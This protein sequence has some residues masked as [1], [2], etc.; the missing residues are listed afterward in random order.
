MMRTLAVELTLL[1][2]VVQTADSATTGP[3][4]SLEY[5]KGANLLGA[6]AAVLYDDVRAEAYT[7][8][9]SGRVRFLDAAPLTE[10]G[11]VGIP[12]PLGWFRS[13]GGEFAS[14]GRL[15]PKEIQC[16]PHVTHDDLAESG[17]EPIRS[18]YFTAGGR[19]I[20]GL[21]RYRLKTSIDRG[22][23]GRPS[24]GSLFG[25]DALAA[26]SRWL[27]RI[28]LDDEVSRDIE[29]RLASV[30]DGELVWLGRSR[31]AEYGRCN[32]QLAN[33]PGAK[34]GKPKAKGGQ[35]REVT[36]VLESDLALYDPQTGEPTWTAR[37][38]LL[39]LP[40]DWQL[41]PLASQVESRSYSPF[42]GKR[43]FRENEHR[44]LTRGSVLTFAAGPQA[45]D[46]SLVA[47]ERWLASGVG[48]FRQEGLGQVAAA[49]WYL[50]SLHPKLPKAVSAKR[51]IEG[52][53]A[54]VAT[55]AD[56]LA[57]WMEKRLEDR[58][59]AESA[60]AGA[61]ETATEL[62][63]LVGALQRKRRPAP[64]RSQWSRVAGLARR[65]LETDTGSVEAVRRMLA[66]EVFGSGEARASVSS[67]L[68]R[69]EI[70]GRPLSSWLLDRGFGDPASG[71]RAR[72]VH[73]HLTALLVARRLSRDG[74]LREEGR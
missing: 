27:A 9:H 39:G 26:G 64:G 59:E 24:P 50:A 41:R 20:D 18:G 65:A 3:H 49:P 43:G 54:L 73:L 60:Y 38:D 15:D 44:V 70:K 6:A 4:R 45:P 19:W 36:L 55:P 71:E 61:S 68:W 17:L 52:E 53:I 14:G 10:E 74:A 37:P 51:P 66:D 5:L 33:E 42:N 46:V 58:V 8:F 57:R 29:N 35:V 12:A 1:S 2:D 63:G 23:G 28:V 22:L 16:L 13:K 69:E 7:V 32:A 11:E 48:L 47:L 25:Y 40:G 72:V 56:S 62:A 34:A 67:N 31:G 21:R 30:F